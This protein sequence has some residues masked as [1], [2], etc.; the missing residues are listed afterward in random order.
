[1]FSEEGLKETRALV[2]MDEANRS[3]EVEYMSKMG[4]TIN[5]IRNVAKEID[6][7][8]IIIGTKG[9]SGLREVLIGS[10]TSNLM[11]TSGC[12]VIAVPENYKYSRPKNIVFAAD[13]RK[14][15]S[16]QSLKALSELAAML[17]SCM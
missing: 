17:I 9:A 11:K 3:L 4:G 12:P 1:M 8:H 10:V 5:E 6:A 16:S 15:E 2:M 13:L 14:A 7:S